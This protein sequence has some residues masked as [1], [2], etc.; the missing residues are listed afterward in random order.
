M[1]PPLFP[2][3]LPRALALLS[4][5]QLACEAWRMHAFYAANASLFA[6]LPLPLFPPSTSASGA[7]DA[8]LELVPD[9]LEVRIDRPSGTEGLPSLRINRPTPL[10]VP[11][12]EK[13]ASSLSLIW[14]YTVESEIGE[15]AKHMLITSE[16]QLRE[17]KGLRW[18]SHITVSARG[19]GMGG[20]GRLRQGEARP[21]GGAGSGG[22]VGDGSGRWGRLVQRGGKRRGW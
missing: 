2:R 10:R 13:L 12:P 4:L 21:G 5:A 16:K 19:E 20:E 17:V 14:R 18:E 7:F 1:A 15:P 9:D 11:L 6:S 3:S 8:L 22:G